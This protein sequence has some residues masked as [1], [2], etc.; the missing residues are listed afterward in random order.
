MYS[1]QYTL[2]GGFKNMDIMFKWQFLEK[3]IPGAPS[4]QTKLY[5]GV[6]I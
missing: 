1:V 4:T 6:R 3:L 5:V 2:S